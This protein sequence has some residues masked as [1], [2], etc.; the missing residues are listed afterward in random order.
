MPFDLLQE[1]PG[2]QSLPVPTRYLELALV[3][4]Q[5]LVSAKTQRRGAL[6]QLML[7]AGGFSLL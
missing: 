7:R 4:N 6:I 1:V 5:E 2:L 3:A